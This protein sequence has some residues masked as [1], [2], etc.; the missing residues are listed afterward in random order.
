M[1][2]PR[3][4]P[5]SRSARRPIRT[6]LPGVVSC[7]AFLI[8][9]QDEIFVYMADRRLPSMTELSES[10]HRIRPPVQRQSSRK[11]GSSL[12]LS[13]DMRHYSIDPQ[14]PPPPLMV[15]PVIIF[16]DSLMILYGSF[17]CSCFIRRQWMAPIS[18]NGHTRNTIFPTIC[19]SATHPT[20]VLRESMDTARLSPM[21]KILPSGTWYG[22]EMLVSP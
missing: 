21:T 6:I 18:L 15:L 4:T 11:R 22:R 1:A 14:K 10:G 19:S 12:R 7:I 16:S 3:V 5:A 8:L 17:I 20:A 9:A 13:S 2:R